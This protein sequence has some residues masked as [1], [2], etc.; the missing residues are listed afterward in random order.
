MRVLIDY[1]PALRERSGVGE[2]THQLAHA[3]L[4]AYPAD[5]GRDSLSLTLFSSS[6]KDRLVPP[7]EL[8]AATIVDRRVPVSVLNFAWHRLEWPPVETLAGARYDVAHSPH[9]LL[10]PT[11]SAAQVITIHDLNFLSHPERTRAEIRRDY[12][13]LARDH[14]HRADAILVPS[15]Y[16][17]GEVERLLGV[18]RERMTIFM[19]GAPDWT[20]R[21]AA[22]KD[23]Y[24]L[25]FSTLEPRKNV[26]GLLDAWERLASHLAPGHAAPQLSPGR[27]SHRRSAAVARTDCPPAARRIRA[28]PRLCR[29]ERS[30]RPL[31]RRAG[32]GPAVLRRRLWPAGARRD[33]ARRAG[34]RGESRCAARGAW[35][36]R[37]AR[38][39]RCPGRYRRGDCARD[40]RR[41]RGRGMRARGVARARAFRWAD[42][43]QRVYATYRQAIDRR[44]QAA[45][46]S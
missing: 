43:A 18:P 28:S 45:R 6:W 30:P 17:A 16:T 23:G 27:T 3:L 9:P 34:G 35:R 10:L 42:T 5:A 39:S 4:T 20:P 21:V 29:R 12:P 13:G 19:P 8:A 2:Q 40:Q 25:F 7:V 15:A 33:D 37:A 14:A 26:G 1:R 32:A 38:G 46:R 22:P 41:R 31:R 44:A 24:V 36:R 11:R